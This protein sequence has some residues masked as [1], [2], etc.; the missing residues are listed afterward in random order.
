MEFPVYTECQRGGTSLKDVNWSSLTPLFNELDTDHLNTIYAFLLHHYVSNG[1][2][3]QSIP[4]E[5][6]FID[7]KQRRGVKYLVSTIPED[8]QK[9]IAYYLTVFVRVTPC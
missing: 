9:T 8:L 7:L 5:G 3:A 1:G 2:N 4:Y 6:T